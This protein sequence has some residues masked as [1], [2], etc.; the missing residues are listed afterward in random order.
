MRKRESGFVGFRKKCG[1]VSVFLC[2]PAVPI[3]ENAAVGVC[4]RTGV[5]SRSRVRPVEGQRA[6]LRKR[7]SGFV[8]FRKK[9]GPVSVFLCRL[10]V[11]ISENVAVGVCARTGVVPRS[12]VRPVE[13]Q[14]ASL[15]KRE[16]GFV[17]FREKCGP[18]SV[19]LCRPAVP[20]S[21]DAAVGRTRTT[22]YLFPY[23]TVRGRE[24][25][26]RGGES[27]VAM[28]RRGARSVK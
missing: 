13:D 8:G 1:P 27:G 21:E 17:G 16:S 28:S 5:V 22:L 3:S 24:V 9:C 10:A 25:H 20:I 19:F 26:C 12:R 14:R 23:P 11:L 4:A 7:E 18:V 15:R 2:R 6:S